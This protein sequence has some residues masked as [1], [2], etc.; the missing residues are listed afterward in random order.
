M[1][2]RNGGAER[3]E[4]AL[5]LHELGAMGEMALAY[6]LGTYENAYLDQ[7]PVRGNSD[8]PGD[9]EVKTR[10]RHC[11]DLIVQEDERPD[12][13]VVLVTIECGFILLQGWCKAADV[14]KEEF[15]EDKALNGRSAYF[16]PKSELKPI[17]TL[18]GE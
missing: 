3:G 13:I 6:H 14:M 7:S 17:A 9:I 4:A 15:W 12:K 8:L 18:K 11:W 16:V 5:K 2:G 1:S 10:A